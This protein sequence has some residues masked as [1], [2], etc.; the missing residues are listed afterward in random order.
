MAEFGMESVLR[1]Y[2]TMLHKAILESIDQ[3]LASFAAGIPQS[4]YYYLERETGL[5]REEVPLKPDVFVQGL[6]LV[7]GEGAET[8]ERRI[9]STILEKFRLNPEKAGSLSLKECIRQVR[10]QF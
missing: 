8:I 10:Q 2:E 4:T 9:I 7:Y 6:R 3:A 1:P 5:K